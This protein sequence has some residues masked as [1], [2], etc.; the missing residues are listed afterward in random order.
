MKNINFPGMSPDFIHLYYETKGFNLKYN[1]EYLGCD[2][3][4]YTG[5]DFIKP[6]TEE[7]AG[8]NQ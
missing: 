3:L 1:F 4:T 5:T 8:A 6:S 7:K 2:F